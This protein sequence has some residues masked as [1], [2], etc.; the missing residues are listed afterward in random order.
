MSIHV[1][2]LIGWL[3]Q[4]A[5]KQ[6]AEDWD[7]VG[8]LVGTAEKRVERVLLAINVTAPVVEEARQL[9]CG[10]IIA[11]HPLIF[12]P[13]RS[14]RTDLAQGSLIE[15]LLK[16]EISLYVAHTNLDVAPDGV[17]AV[18]ASSLGLSDCQVLR[19]TGSERFL[20][21]AVYVPQSH[22]DAVRDALAAT[23]AGQLGDYARCSFAVPGTGTF[24]PLAGADPYIGQVG[25][26]TSVSEVRLETM[27]PES[28]LSTCLAAMKRA[29]PYES[30]AYDLVQ[31]ENIETKRGLGL[32]GRL[33]QPQPLAQVLE[34]TKQRLQTS[35]LRFVGDPAQLVQRVAVC[36]GSGGDLVYA[37]AGRADVLITGDIGYHQALDAEG[38]GL[39]LVDAGHFPTERL[40][41]PHLRELLLQNIKKPSVELLISQSEQ[42]VWRWLG[43]EQA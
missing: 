15:S 41:L 26:L 11:H 5:P 25:Q 36:G 22:L 37:A 16:A 20:K 13:L 2:T 24:L 34:L 42:D 10:L 1:Q 38:Q 28:K 18:L 6:W 29:H 30:V 43:A 3:E 40:V 35:S 39:A 9:G 8:L 27:V 14:V 19:P 12:K 32:V 23:G 7:N 33:S 4:L 21:L 17:N 31:L